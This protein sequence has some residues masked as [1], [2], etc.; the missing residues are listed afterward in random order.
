MN[1]TLV[2]AL[3][4]IVYIALLVSATLY[5]EESFL[6]LFGLFLLQAVNEFTNLV[7]MN[8]WLAFLLA[9]ISYLNFTYFNN[10]PFNNWMLT[11]I[12]L[13]VLI[14]L[15]SWL[16]NNKIKNITAL[17]WILLIGYIIIPF[18]LITKLGEINDNHYPHIII[19][20]FILIW[21]NDTFA[22]IVGKKI[23]KRKLFEKISPKKTIE[24]FL[25]GA[26]FAILASFIIGIY[27][28]NLFPLVYWVLIALFT[29]CFGTIGDLVESKFKRLAGVKDSGNI[30]PGHG[31]ILDRLDSIIFTTPF[32]YLLLK[33]VGYVS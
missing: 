7:R 22:Y 1:E 11:I 31:G 29:S 4:G 3:S 10:Y 2:R 8:K 20:I 17:H 9:I 13:M 32:V 12:S 27:Y 18:I 14:F 30:M 25:G 23:G 5:S 33:I 6:I 24:G 28:V 19:A 26:L 21:T 15:C 16:F